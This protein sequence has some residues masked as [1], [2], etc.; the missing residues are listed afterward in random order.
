MADRDSLKRISLILLLLSLGVRLCFVPLAGSLRLASDESYYWNDVAISVA[1][2]S[3]LTV[4]HQLRP[5]LWGYLLALP[6]RISGNPFFGRLFA[7]LI[8]SLSAVFVFLLGTRLSDRRAAIASGTLFA[9]YP[10]HVYF[11]HYL[12]PEVLFGLL[13]VSASMLFLRSAGNGRGESRRDILLASGVL[14][15]ALLAKEFAVIPMSAMLLLAPDTGWREKAG[16]AVRCLAVFLLPALAYS[17]LSWAVAG[18]PVILSRAPV[19]NLQQTVGVAFDNNVD[20]SDLDNFVQGFLKKTPGEHWR[21]FEDQVIKLW[22]PNSFP[23]VRLLA[24][25]PDW[26]ITD[27]G[28]EA[29]WKKAQATVVGAGHILIMTAGLLGL[30][31][32]PSG[33]F[34]RYAILNLCLLTSVGAVALIASRFRLPF[35]FLLVLG[36]GHAIVHPKEVGRRLKDRKTLVLAIVLFSLL[37]FI[38]AVSW[39]CF[40]FWG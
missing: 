7:I 18:K 37:A 1:H 26:V 9:L 20:Y 23:I 19:A 16:T 35:A 17:L 24:K 28:Y 12:W 27:W 40:G 4:E 11:S 21:F 5:P 36:A 38:T 10:E 39:H 31:A 33:V 34:R 8:G 15:F 25:G 13:V 30:L 6:A 3:V 29:R 2:G 22:S 32:L 14:G